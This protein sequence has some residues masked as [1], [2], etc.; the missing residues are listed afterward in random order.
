[1]STN[2]GVSY[3]NIT[4]KIY[5]YGYGKR[6]V[7]THIVLDNERV[8]QFN[9]EI[10]F[11]TDANNWDLQAVIEYF[12]VIAPVVGIEIISHGFQVKFRTSTEANTVVKVYTMMNNEKYAKRLRSCQLNK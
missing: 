10:A 1:M 11:L 4:N 9:N 3:K 6:D 2:D 7:L 5:K 12:N 8:V